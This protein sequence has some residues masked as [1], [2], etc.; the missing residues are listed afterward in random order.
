M[1]EKSHKEF[2]G[3]SVFDTYVHHYKLTLKATLCSD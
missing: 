3:G 1:R 2:T